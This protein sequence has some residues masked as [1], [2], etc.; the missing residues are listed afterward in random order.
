MI[1]EKMLVKDKKVFVVFMDLEK[2]C[3]RVDWEA[4][5]DVLEVYGVCG[6]LLDGVK[7]SFLQRC[8][9]MCPS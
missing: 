3:D 4:V 7:V 6:R 2:T 8:Q 9:R 1:I 5:Q